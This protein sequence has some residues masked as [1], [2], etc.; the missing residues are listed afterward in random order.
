M[1]SLAGTSSVIQSDLPGYEHLLPWLANVYV[2][3]RYRNMGIGTRLIEYAAK[4]AADLGTRQLFLYTFDKVPYYE[5]MGWR[6]Q[7]STTY[8]GKPITIMNRVLRP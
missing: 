6:A 5:G 7:E 1:N 2:E 8:L 3:P 4:F